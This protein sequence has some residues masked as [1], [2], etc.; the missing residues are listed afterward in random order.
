MLISEDRLPTLSASQ[1]LQ[2]LSS[3]PARPISTGLP[4]LDAYLQGIELS[5]S[6]DGP[7]SGGV[8]RGEVT[9]VNESPQSPG[10]LL[11]SKLHQV[12]GPPGVGKT[13]FAYVRKSCNHPCRCA[14]VHANGCRMQVASNALRAG[15]SVVW[16]GTPPD[17]NCR[18]FAAG[19]SLTNN[20]PRHNL[21]P[22]SL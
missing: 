20:V 12:F 17:L 3:T 9:E 22:C 14:D 1:A 7:S 13:A 8:T 10:A 16:V 6:Q 2:N 11:K 18:L 4:V 21:C 15:S 19:R 5:G